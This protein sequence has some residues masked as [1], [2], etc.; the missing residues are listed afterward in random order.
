MQTLKRIY[1]VAGSMGGGG[2]EQVMPNAVKLPNVGTEFGGW[3]CWR[4]GKG[5]G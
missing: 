3:N 2:T 5:K 4:I 1:E